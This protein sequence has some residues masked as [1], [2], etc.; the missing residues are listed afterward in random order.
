[1]CV[2]SAKPPFPFCAKGPLPK[3]DVAKVKDG[4]IADPSANILRGE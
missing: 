4:W 2:G 3:A 1:M